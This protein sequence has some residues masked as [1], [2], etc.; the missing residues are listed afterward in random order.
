MNKKNLNKEEKDKNRKH[1]LSFIDKLFIRI[2]FSSLVL[3]SLVGLDRITYFR[4]NM[5]RNINF[6]HYAKLFNGVFGNYFPTSDIEVSGLNYYD[7]IV[8]NDATLENEINNYSSNVIQPLTEGVVSKISKNKDG[9]YDVSIIDNSGYETTYKGLTQIDVRIYS[10]VFL[11]TI[12]GVSKYDE[13][14]ECY[15]FN[16]VIEKDGKYYDYYEISKD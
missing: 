8:F 15:S 4:I 6:L 13:I 12:I 2:F 3:L 7:I 5:N 1:K 10:Y 16:I 9:S 11:D 14:K